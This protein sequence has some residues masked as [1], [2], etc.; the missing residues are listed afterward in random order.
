MTQFNSLPTPNLKLLK[1][2]RAIDTI[3]EENPKATKKTASE[4]ELKV[5]R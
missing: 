3:T 4:L 5:L 2:A 1:P